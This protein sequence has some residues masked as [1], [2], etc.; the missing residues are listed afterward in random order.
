MPARWKLLAAL[1]LVASAALPQYT[2]VTYRAP[3][4]GMWQ[5]LP[6]GADSTRYERLVEPHY[7]F[8]HWNPGLPEHWLTV[9]CFG[10][11]LAVLGIRSRSRLPRVKAVLWWLEPLLAVGSG[12][13]ILVFSGFGQ[14]AVGA[15]LGLAA[16]G[17]YF[18]TWAYEALSRFRKAPA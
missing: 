10:W 3:D 11:P 8:E 6:P 4:G 5:T 12:Y 15:Y 18:V 1:L 17:A 9:L 14:R 16:C 2:C 13:L 7:A